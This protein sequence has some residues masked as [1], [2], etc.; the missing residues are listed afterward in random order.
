LR[1]TA[2]AFRARAVSKT[3]RKS[4]RAFIDC[5]MNSVS[6]VLIAASLAV[7]AFAF[8]A[9]RLTSSRPIIF[10]GLIGSVAIL[11]AA[12]FSSAHDARNLHLS[13]V[14]PLVVSM[15]FDGRAIG[16][17]IRSKN[18]PELKTPAFLLFAAGAVAMIGFVA[19]FVTK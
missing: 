6:I 1:K 2:N 11:F 14:I 17:L 18:E 12:H 15:A 9:W 8:L 7:L 10:N 4:A 5:R 3:L 16:L 13:Y 19:A